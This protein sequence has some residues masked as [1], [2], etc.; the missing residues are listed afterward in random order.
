MIKWLTTL[1]VANL[2]KVS[3][4]AIEKR[5]SAGKYNEKHIKKEKGKGGRQGIKILVDLSTLSPKAQDRY[6]KQKVKEHDNESGADFLIGLTEKQMS[7]YNDRVQMIQ[8]ALDL[9][10]NGKGRHAA[11]LDLATEYGM[12]YMNLTRWIKRYNNEGLQSLVTKT[13]DDKG[14]VKI[15][16]RVQEKIINLYFY[17]ARASMTQVY[18][19]IKL[20]CRNQNLH[21]CHYATMTRFIN[22]WEK[23]NPQDAY[24][25]RHGIRAARQKFGIYIPRDFSYLMPNDLWMGD[26][27]PIDILVVN[28]QTKKP[29]RPWITAWLDV[30]TRVVMGYHVSFQPSSTT[31]ALALKHGICKEQFF[32]IPKMV[33]IDNG[34]DFRANMFGG[35]MKNFGK[36]DFNEETRSVFS[37]LGISVTYAMPYNPR[38]KAQIERWFGTLERGWINILPGYTG[39]D[40]KHRP[41]KLEQEIKNDKLLSLIQFKEKL[42]DS[43]NAYHKRPHRSLNGKAPLELFAE[44]WEREDKIDTTSLS[45]LLLKKSTRTVARDGIHING[46]RYFSWDPDFMHCV[47]KKAVVRW[48]PD[49]PT[50]INISVGNNHFVWIEE[51]NAVRFGDKDAMTRVLKLQKKQDKRWRE[52]VR[53]TATEKA[54]IDHL[55]QEGQ[56]IEEVEVEPMAPE[57]KILHMTGLEEKTREEELR[58][59]RKRKDEKPKEEFYRYKKGVV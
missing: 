18:N 33:Y 35:R 45:L 6:W 24:A 58:E 29:D 9:P 39:H 12:T 44:M 31:I 32:G 54:E 52:T 17:E 8:K 15:D 3:K 21:L 25:H 20:F 1:E 50:R 14:Q 55:L 59:K 51:A 27:T 28:P 49:D 42:A 57:K 23:D 56:I 46:L 26:H 22:S 36:I 10:M 5:I 37:T 40:V 43:I 48:D 38:A 53:K 34:K 19:S 41:E 30:R 13:R 7:L 11:M 2:E 16:P 47:G 4:R